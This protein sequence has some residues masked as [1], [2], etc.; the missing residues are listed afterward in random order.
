LV[1]GAQLKVSWQCPARA[2][3]NDSEGRIAVAKIR[4]SKAFGIHAVEAVSMKL[5]LTTSA[6]KLI[7]IFYTIV[8]EVIDYQHVAVLKMA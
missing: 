1:S 7:L 3:G 4:N 8:S 2:T 5:H 6:A